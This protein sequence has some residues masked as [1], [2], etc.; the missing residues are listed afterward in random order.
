MLKSY[1]FQK[2]HL[3]VWLASLTSMAVVWYATASF[4]LLLTYN[5]DWTVL[6]IVFII[7]LFPAFFSQ[8]G[9]ILSL[10]LERKG[11]IFV[12]IFVLFYLLA[13]LFVLSLIFADI[14][15]GLFFSGLQLFLLTLLLILFFG[16]CVYAMQTAVLLQSIISES[17]F[18]KDSKVNKPN[19]K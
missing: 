6:L 15:K 12:R 14:L 3:L 7:A 10:I 18:G 16:I 2:R 1:R 5:A 4:I 8:V 17:K 19:P 13:A 9:L 11:N